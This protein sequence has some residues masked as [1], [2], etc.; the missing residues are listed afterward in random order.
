MSFFAMMIVRGVSEHGS[1]KEVMSGL[2]DTSHDEVGRMLGHV[3]KYT[4]AIEGTAFLIMG[5]WM[6]WGPLASVAADANL[7]PWWFGL[8]HA[9][10]A[11]NNAGFGLLNDN[12]MKFV[13]DPV[14]SLTIA[15]LIILGGIGYPVLIF[16]HTWLRKKTTHRNDA[17]QKALEQ[18]V[19]D[20]VASPLQTKI[21][22][23]GTLIL[24][25]VGTILVYAIEMKN[26]LVSSY[27]FWQQMLIHFFQ[28]TSTRTAGFNTIDLG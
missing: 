23:W 15:F 12:L 2:I 26:P 16:I 28:S 7:N 18:D 8:F 1:F 17:A 4:L 3:L 10:S 6:Q 9:I 27:S 14:I 11:F 20:V 24:L 19:K 22:L 21:A 25:L 5:S 13:T